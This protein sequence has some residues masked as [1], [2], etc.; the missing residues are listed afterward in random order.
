M[1]RQTRK[2][3]LQMF[4]DMAKAPKFANE[5]DVP[6]TILLPAFVTSELKT[7]FRSASCSICPF[8]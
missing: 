8:W 3:D 7:A 5:K 2:T 6:F 4:A 1:I